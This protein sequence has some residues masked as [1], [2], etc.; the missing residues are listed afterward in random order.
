MFGLYCRSVLLLQS[1]FSLSYKVLC[2]NCGTALSVLVKAFT[3]NVFPASGNQRLSSF[4]Y[5]IKQAFHLLISCDLSVSP[6]LCF[7]SFII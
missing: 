3:S 6:N 1:C 2:L 5:N 4:S 7:K